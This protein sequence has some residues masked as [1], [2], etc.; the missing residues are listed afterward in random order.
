MEPAP[1]DAAELPGGAPDPVVTGALEG[2]AGGAL[3]GGGV[4]AGCEVAGAAGVDDGG[5]GVDPGFGS[6]Y[7]PRG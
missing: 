3:L 1:V 7:A 2:L 6:G 4:A 5:G